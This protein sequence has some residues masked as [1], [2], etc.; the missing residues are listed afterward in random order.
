MCLHTHIISLY[1]LKTRVEKILVL[2]FI[3]KETKVS[4]EHLAQGHTTG[5][6]SAKFQSGALSP[7][8]AMTPRSHDAVPW[9]Y[10]DLIESPYAVCRKVL[11]KKLG[12]KRPNFLPQP[13]PRRAVCPR[14]C[15]S[16]QQLR[17]IWGMRG[18]EQP[19]HPQ[20]CLGSWRTG[21]HIKVRNRSPQKNACA[22]AHV[23]PHKHTHT[24]GNN[25]RAFMDPS[26]TR[27]L[28]ASWFLRFVYALKFCTI[29]SFSKHSDLYRHTV[30]S[31]CV[32]L[33]SSDTST[34]VLEKCV[35]WRSKVFTEIRPEIWLRKKCGFR[36][37]E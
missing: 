10:R 16:P 34:F 11:R 36:S 2:N 9:V 33:S 15:L 12:F 18:L 23:N 29:F 19:G 20:Q 17:T 21:K 27:W 1:L 4:T 13:W 31:M 25:F 26:K 7:H 22:H 30:S 32:N 24:Q 8:C 5:E 3:N 6:P 37:R 14:V 35:F 28:L